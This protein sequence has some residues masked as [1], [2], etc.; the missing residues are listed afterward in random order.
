[1]AAYRR[2]YYSRHLQDDCQ[3]TGIS[4]GT[5]RSTV[6]YGIPLPFNVMA[7]GGGRRPGR[8]LPRFGGK[9]PALA[10]GGWRSINLSEDASWRAVITSVRRGPKS[11]ICYPAVSP[12]DMA[13]SRAPRRRPQPGRVRACSQ[14]HKSSEIR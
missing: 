7:F 8:Q 5:L 12:S 3:K 14:I 9:C 11:A 13:R 2:V 4:S 10:C 6:E 1:M